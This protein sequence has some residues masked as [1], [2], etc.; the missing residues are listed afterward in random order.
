MN[1]LDQFYFRQNEPLKS[2]FLALR[3]IILQHDE[4]LTETLKYGMPC[5]CYGKK[6][7]CYLWMDKK[8]KEPYLL[9]AEG[10]RL[11][12]PQLEKGSRSK[13]KIFPLTTMEDI[14]VKSIRALLKEALLLYKGN[15]A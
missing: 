8:T 1:E 12:H 11:H 4:K 7:V 6:I 13:M 9:M 15:T 10:K 2:Y 14:P 3:E 5:F